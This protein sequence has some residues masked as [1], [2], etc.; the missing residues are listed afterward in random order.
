[1]R[2]MPRDHQLNVRLTA[3]TMLCLEALRAPGESQA[4][5]ITD[6]LLAECERRWHG[7]AQTGEEELAGRYANALW[8]FDHEAGRTDTGRRPSPPRRGQFWDRWPAPEETELAAAL[9]A[10][11]QATGSRRTLAGCM[12]GAVLA[13]VRALLAGAGDLPADHPARQRCAQAL[14]AYR[15]LVAPSATPEVTGA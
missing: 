12:A 13:E 4:D 9:A 6:L 3:A 1:M 5:V 11:W 7:F 8:H 2:I 14:Q 15:T 10:A